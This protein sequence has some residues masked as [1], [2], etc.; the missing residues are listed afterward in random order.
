MEIFK[1]KPTVPVQ[2][3]LNPEDKKMYFVYNLSN[4]K[5]NYNQLKSKYSYKKNEFSTNGYSFCNVTMMGMALD[6]LGFIPAF[7]RTIESTYPELDRLPDKLAKHALESPRVLA[8]YKSRFPDW[9]EKFEK[10]DKDAYGPNEIH[11]V[12][13][14]AVNDFLNVPC[15]TYFSTNTSWIEIM[16]ELVFWGRPVGISGKFS[17]L[18]HIVLAVGCAFEDLGN[19]SYPSMD[20]KPNFFI[21]DDPYGKTYEYGKGLS[22]NDVWIPFEKCV[23]DFKDLS[24]PSFKFTHRFIAPA[25]LGIM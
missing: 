21:V 11:S 15:A 16:N 13:S 9:Y 18:N 2:R 3:F 19:D 1:Y 22:G 24:D 8:Y 10:G 17:G 14:Y 6:Y 20:Q 5:S 12:L 4:D 25:N 7:K 23:S